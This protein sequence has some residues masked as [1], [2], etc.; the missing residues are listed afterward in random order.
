MRTYHGQFVA[1]GTP[2]QAYQDEQLGPVPFACDCQLVTT[3]TNHIPR[4]VAD[5]VS[6]QRA[7]QGKGMREYL[8]QN[9]APLGIAA[10]R[11]TCGT[12][13]VGDLD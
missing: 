13:A 9:V 12:C 10:P 8:Q 11:R 2:F 1:G 6:R 5:L 3:E 7:E 4:E